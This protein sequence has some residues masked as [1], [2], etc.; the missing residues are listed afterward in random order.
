VPRNERQKEARR[1]EGIAQARQE[2]LDRRAMSKEQF[3]RYYK[4]QTLEQQRAAASSRA[5]RDALSAE[6]N[7]MRA[8]AAIQSAQATAERYKQ[9]EE[10]QRAEATLRYA[11]DALEALTD[12]QAQFQASLKKM[13]KG[14]RGRAID[15]RNEQIKALQDQ[16]DAARNILMSGMGAPSPG[17]ASLLDN[18]GVTRAF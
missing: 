1:K 14:E 9:S 2:M 6:L 10:R 15:A 18:V 4:M 12:S 8:G 17:A 13:K 11:G 7:L 5:E 3:D 16:M